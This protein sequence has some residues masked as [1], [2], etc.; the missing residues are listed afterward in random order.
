[1][2]RTIPLGKLVPS[3]RNVRRRIDVDADLELKADIAARG[4]LQ[5]LVVTQ[6]KKPRGCFAVEAGER[7]RRALQGLAD[8]GALPADHEVPC[9]V[10]DSIA[11]GHEASLAENFQRLAMNPADECLA[12]QAL[13]EQGAE[14]EGVAR[15]F[16]LTERFVEGRLLLAGLA[17]V[18]FEAL[19]AGEISLDVAK[20]FAAT[21]DRERQAWVFEQLAG[22]SAVY[23]DSVRRMM[24]QATV[25][26]VDRRA[27]LVGE[28]AYLAAGGRIERDL[29]AD[30]DAARWLD[31]ALLER[32][33]SE[34]ME[35]LASEVASEVG[36]AFVRPTLESWV[37]YGR[38][39]GLV[40]V[41][42]E[43][44][45]LDDDEKAEIDALQAEIDGLADLLED[46]EADPEG[47]DQA[48]ARVA[49]LAARIE[50]IAEKP[51]VLGDELKGQVG[52]FLL[53]GDDG[54]PR[55]DRGYFR[56][57]VEEERDGD[58]SNAGRGT[59]A[60]ADARERKPAG[61]SQRL[62]D[63]LAIQRRD[64]LALHLAADSAV[65]L[66]LATFLMAD[67]E[68]GGHWRDRSGS[69]L[70]ASPPSDPVFGFRTPGAAATL[71]LAQVGEAL[72]RS[73]TAGETRAERFDAFRALPDAARMAWLGH[74][75]ARTLEASL[76]YPGERACAL[77]DHLGQVLGIE[78]A[79][80]WRP[81]GAN[82]FDRVPKGMALAALAEVGGQALADRHA[83]AK[84]AGLAEACERLF[85]GE[86]VVEA[87]VRAAA[88]AWVPEAMR[89]ASAHSAD[90]DA[91][92]GDRTG[93]EADIDAGAGVP[94]VAAAGSGSYT[95]AGSDRGTA[96]EAGPGVDVGV[97]A[98]TGGDPATDT[99]PG[100]AGDAGHGV[101]VGA[102]DDAGREAGE[103]A[104]E[105]EPLEEAA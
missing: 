23:P 6:A 22:Y 25:S 48:E 60:A 53:L 55:L 5:N 13:V 80:W 20:A 63:E 84:K 39:D 97:G 14:V 71:G 57:V 74:C 79:R 89:F 2:I 12:F 37:G 10:V 52:T 17:P 96:G 11:D 50:A 32:L 77:H 30:D 69:S 100:V 95:D 16:G 26:A 33:A 62:V 73:W 104:V 75:I 70:V 65:A 54:V 43:T 82:Y 36:L 87:E 38:L 66:G 9:L 101:D 3:P 44:P 58:A 45:E 102:D 27:R 59:T 103:G 67:R 7:R 98:G 85:A 72:D 41:P 42:L 56:E 88:L 4:L 86:L 92:A 47:Q 29:F 40:R 21:P 94:A 61:L 78:V 91:E 31:V 24:T 35:R 34:T 18:V 19:G 105:P 28:E 93:P 8:D 46:E 76:N 90:A 1:M 83:K 49:E 64:V 51:P 99:N 81:T 15:R 68:T